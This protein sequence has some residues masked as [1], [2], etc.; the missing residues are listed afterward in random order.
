[1]V[2]Q[3]RKGVDGF[4]HNAKQSPTLIPKMEAIT[5]CLQIFALVMETIIRE[6]LIVWKEEKA[7]AL[8]LHEE[9]MQPVTPS[10]S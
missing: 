5:F 4:L 10:G 2:L 8:L 1:M 6:N 9:T 3:K 7:K